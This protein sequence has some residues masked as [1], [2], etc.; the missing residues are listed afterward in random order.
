[1]KNLKMNQPSMWIFG[2]A[3]TLL[4]APLI[5]MQFTSEVQWDI[6]DFLIMG[7]LLFAVATAVDLIWKKVRASR[8]RFLYIALVL[9]LLLMIWAELAVGV[10][11]NPFAGS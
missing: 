2:T 10:F 4:T 9:M 8:K 6:Y 11:G 7:V 3:A 5:A 1:M